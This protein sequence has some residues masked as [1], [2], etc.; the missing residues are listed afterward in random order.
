MAGVRLLPLLLPLLLLLLLLLRLRPL[1]LRLLADGRLL[2]PSTLS[3]QSQE[4]VS[5]LYRRPP[6][7]SCSVAVP[8]Q[9]V[10]YLVHDDSWPKMPY[11]QSQ[12]SVL[13]GPSETGNKNN[14]KSKRVAFL[15][16]PCGGDSRVISEATAAKPDVSRNRL[17]STAASSAQ[18]EEEAVSVCVTDSVCL[19][20]RVASY[21]AAVSGRTD[22]P[23]TVGGVRDDARLVLAGVLDLLALGL[24]LLLRAAS[25]N[26]TRANMRKHGFHNTSGVR[27]LLDEHILSVI[28]SQAL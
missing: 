12:C 20:E 10:Q 2:R 4:C 14:C 22:S 15:I 3:G 6:M 19:G 17:G 16:K 21:R 5:S 8:F 11:S 28:T 1:L 7:Q 25:W 23:I 18:P 13:M 27:N 24:A 9:H 26:R